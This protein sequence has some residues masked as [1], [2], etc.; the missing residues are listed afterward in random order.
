MQLRL[1]EE[2]LKRVRATVAEWLGRKA[3]RRRELESLVSLLQHAERVV[4]PGVRRIIVVM[5]TVNDRDRFV[6][7]NVEIQSDLH[8]WSEFVSK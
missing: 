3:G 7:L 8:L 5:T 1:P 2:K 4:Q 6:C